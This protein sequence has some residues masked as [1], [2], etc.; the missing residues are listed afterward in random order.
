MLRIKDIKD[1][2]RK[3]YKITETRNLKSLCAWYISFDIKHFAA[4]FVTKRYITVGPDIMN[5]NLSVSFEIQ[6][7]LHNP[8]V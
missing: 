7:T 1:L 6:A 2:K 4:N 8:D 5:I 3:K